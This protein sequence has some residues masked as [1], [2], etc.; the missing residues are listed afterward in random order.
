MDLSLG[1]SHTTWGVILIIT[2]L[3]WLV[4]IP[5]GLAEEKYGSLTVCLRY[6]R[7]FDASFGPKV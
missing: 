7:Y 5:K 6:V 2:C 4:S 3:Y 1:L